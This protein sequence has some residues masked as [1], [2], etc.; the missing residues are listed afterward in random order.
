MAA[1]RVLQLRRFGHGVEFIRAAIENNAEKDGFEAS[2][3][4]SS[5][6]LTLFESHLCS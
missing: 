1:A 3:C 6:S 4:I 2:F 5:F